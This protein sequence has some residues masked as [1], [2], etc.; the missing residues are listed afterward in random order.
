MFFL[1]GKRKTQFYIK[2]SLE[3]KQLDR[4]KLQLEEM[5]DELQ[6]LLP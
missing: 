1:A 5:F 4:F 2:F 6:E 3:K